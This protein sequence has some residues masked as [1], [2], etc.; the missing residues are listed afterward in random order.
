MSFWE[1]NGGQ[2]Q[3]PPLTKD[4]SGRFMEA[5]AALTGRQLSVI[6]MALSLALLGTPC[7]VHGEE[8]PDAPGLPPEVHKLGQMMRAIMV[9][10][11]VGSITGGRGDDVPQ[12]VKDL[13]VKTV[14]EDLEAARA[15]ISSIMEDA[16]A[17]IAKRDNEA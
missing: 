13:L 1:K 17:E 16:A 8:C 14:R 10:L 6:H 2:H 9:Q 4:S 12:G 5:N 11:I 3:R 7:E 15:T